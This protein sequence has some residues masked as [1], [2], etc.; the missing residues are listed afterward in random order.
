M[1]EKNVTSSLS[2]RAINRLFSLSEAKNLSIADR[3]LYRS[4]SLTPGINALARLG[5]TG[6]FSADRISLRTAPKS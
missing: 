4:G 3:V 5:I 6:V 2:K 1:N